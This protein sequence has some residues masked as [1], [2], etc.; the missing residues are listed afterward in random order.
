MIEQKLQPLVTAIF[1][2]CLAII[3]VLLSAKPA[4]AQDS[5][6]NYTY[7]E[8]HDEDFS[9][10]DLK[11]GVF[12]AADVRNSTFAGSDLSNSILTKA[13]FLNTDLSGINLTSSLMDRVAL[14]NCDLTN[15]IMQDI[16]ATSTS[17]ED[18]DITGADFT[19]A[20][21]DRYQVYLLCQRAEGVNPTTGVATKD[22]LLC[23]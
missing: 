14:E 9:G 18:T 5:A 15:A 4:L 17:F 13:A 7:S 12:A 10:K 3:L 8:L 11:G 20:I 16:V 19:G 6:V 22:S 1:L 21:L 23:R 2:I